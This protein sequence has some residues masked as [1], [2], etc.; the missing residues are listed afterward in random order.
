M[1]KIL[2]LNNLDNTGVAVDDIEKGE[3]VPYL[4]EDE[5]ITLTALEA[6]PFGFKIALRDIPK[7]GDVTKY[8]QVIGAARRSILI[9]ELVHVHNVEG[10]RGR[11]DLQEKKL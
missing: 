5:M 11:G 7:G 3:T 10:K 6:V 1:E 4:K 9:G 8:G 2:I